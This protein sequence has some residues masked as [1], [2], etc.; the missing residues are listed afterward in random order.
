LLDQAIGRA[1]GQS[2]DLPLEWLSPLHDDS[3]YAEYSDGDALSKL[4]LQTPRRPLKDFWPKQGPVWDG[5]AT[6]P[7]GKA[8]LVEAKAHIS[9]LVSSASA[10]KGR[11]L[12]MIRTSLLA[13]RRAFGSRS[14]ND[15]T[16]TFYQYANRLAHLYFLRSINK[17]PAYLAFV[18]FTH[19]HAMNGGATEE[20]WRGAAKVVHTY[21][22]L[23]TSNP[24]SRYI[25][26]VFIDVRTLRAA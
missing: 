10:A 22:G 18:Y 8:V 17:Q 26:D 21:L 24:L 3:D 19:D 15:W 14:R 9:E 25:A 6:S 5:L 11:S 1:F 7:T 16:G 13:T 2:L 20:E 23:H 12:D 4:R